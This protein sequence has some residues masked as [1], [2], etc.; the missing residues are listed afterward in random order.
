MA[1]AEKKIRTPN[2][3]AMAFAAIIIVMFM[4]FLN[5]DTE[6]Y[7]DIVQRRGQVANSVKAGNLDI[8]AIQVGYEQ[9]AQD[10]QSLS[11]SGKLGHVLADLD[12]SG[13][14][15]VTAYI[16]V[17][18]TRMMTLYMVYFIIRE[19]VLQMQIIWYNLKNKATR[20]QKKSLD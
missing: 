7:L 8:E 15:Q 17:Y 12:R 9:C 4:L 1:K 18:G 11:E 13:I 14:G 20:K 2:Y 16:L 19:M 3:H 10:M 6:Q 5:R